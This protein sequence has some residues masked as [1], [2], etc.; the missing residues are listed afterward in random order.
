MPALVLSPVHMKNS[1]STLTPPPLAASFI[2]VTAFLSYHQSTLKLDVSYEQPPSAWFSTLIL[3]FLRR[4]ETNTNK[5]YRPDTIFEW[6]YLI[7]NDFQSLSTVIASHMIKWLSF[8]SNLHTWFLCNW[9]F[10]I[11][12]K[13]SNN[14][15]FK[16]L[17]IVALSSFIGKCRKQLDSTNNLNW[18]STLLLNYQRI[19]KSIKYKKS[20]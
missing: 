8:P 2:Y 1:M 20:N 15:L 18:F 6:K 10:Y 17:F 16:L 19:E 5:M 14:E 13:P 3:T 11:I 7:E 12:F 4:V 9:Q